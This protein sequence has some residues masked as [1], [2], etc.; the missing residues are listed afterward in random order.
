M[1]D[2]KW[3]MQRNGEHKLADSVLLLNVNRMF[4][5]NG[6]SVSEAIMLFQE[7]E[8]TIEGRVF[9]YSRHLILPIY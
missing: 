1:N 3:N 7:V 2:G 9:K 5:G 6:N 8:V 4:V